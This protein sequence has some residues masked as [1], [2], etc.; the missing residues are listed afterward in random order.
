MSLKK[1]SQKSGDFYYSH[2]LYDKAKGLEKGIIAREVLDLLPKTN[3]LWNKI[4][5][6][7]NKVLGT[8]KNNDNVSV[9]FRTTSNMDLIKSE[10]FKPELLNH[11]PIQIQLKSSNLF[12]DKDFKNVYNKMIYPNEF[13]N[14][15]NAD[16]KL[17]NTCKY[18]LVIHDDEKEKLESSHFRLL[19]VGI[20]MIALSIIMGAQ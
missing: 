10:S 1:S 19:T 13:R 2:Y 5:E 12:Y 4:E 11:T 18:I 17:Y 15:S 7:K 3:T 14:D 16:V 6:P 8:I 20:P 9:S